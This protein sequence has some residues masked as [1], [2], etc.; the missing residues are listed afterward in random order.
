MSTSSAM[1]GRGPCG[2]IVKWCTALAVAIAVPAALAD[3]NNRYTFTNREG[4]HAHDLHIEFDRAVKWDI[5]D[6]AR[7]WQVPAGTFLGA[8]GSDT[9]KVDLV[10]AGGPGVD[11]DESL[12]LDLMF[13]SNEFPQ[14]SRWYWTKE[15]GSR[16]GKVKCPDK[17][18]VKFEY[19]S[20]LGGGVYDIHA[21]GQVTR[22][23]TLEGEPSEMAA[24][25]MAQQINEMLLF[26]RANSQPELRSVTFQGTAF[27]VEGD[28]YRVLVWEQDRAGPL[29]IT[30][31]VYCPADLNEDGQVDFADYLDFLNFYDDQ[32][33][34]ADFNRDGLVDFADY[35]EFLNFYSVGCTC[36]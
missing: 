14:V 7:E 20:A 2:R 18:R 5:T 19:F 23:L 1:T 16:L 29:M 32:D 35:L 15:D 27:A 28:D 21:H 34:S 25:R 9:D 30:R 12:A 33:P 26:A 10:E 24:V 4:E 36:E 13:P 31:I 17:E 11:E 3:G 22:F 8:V 6:R